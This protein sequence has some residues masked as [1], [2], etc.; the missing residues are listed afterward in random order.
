MYYIHSCSYNYVYLNTIYYIPIRILSMCLVGETRARNSHKFSSKCL[1]S[2]VDEQYPS[3]IPSTHK[4]QNLL[5]NC[6]SS[7]PLCHQFIYRPKLD[8]LAS[9]ELIQG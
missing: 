2:Y 1:R 3:N 5:E 7:M 6:T 8:A 9:S 4:H